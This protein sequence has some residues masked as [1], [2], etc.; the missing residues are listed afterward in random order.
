MVEE[1]ENIKIFISREIPEIGLGLLK[2]EGFKITIWKE[3][4]PVTQQELIQLV[5]KHNALLSMGSDKID[6]YFLN[7]CRHLDII[8][9]FAVGYDNID[10]AE[11][12]RLKI[13]VGNTPGVLSDATADIAFGLM[14]ATSRKMFFM[15]KL[16]TRGEWNYFF[17][18]ANLGIELRNKTLGIFG[19]GRIGYEMASR[20]RGAFNMKVIYCNRNQ[21]REAEKNLKAEKVSFDRLL[22]ESDVLSIHC[23]LSAETKGIFDWNAFKKMKPTSLFINTARGQ[24][25]NENDL[26]RALNE[27]IIWG[28]GLD[29]TNPEPMHPGNPLLEMENVS[30][31]PHIGSATVEARNEMARLAAE[32]IIGF[33]RAK[34]VPNILNPEALT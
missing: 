18:K 32:N 4:I 6:K 2:N 21:N 11:A 27:K 16:I 20:S 10:I 25:H 29:V 7:E 1:K 24:V 9:Q 22:S 26:I 12:S 13:P 5:K 15:H 14:I 31:L 23:K 33:Y 30:V 19:L 28:A 17:P 8:S 34:T 3:A